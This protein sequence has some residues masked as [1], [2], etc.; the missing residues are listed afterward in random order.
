MPCCPDRG[1]VTRSYFRVTGTAPHHYLLPNL[2]ATESL[3]AILKAE[4]VTP[5]GAAS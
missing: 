3:F 5:L 1:G 4:E 2:F